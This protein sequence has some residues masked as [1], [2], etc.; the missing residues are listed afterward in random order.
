MNKNDI[1]VLLSARLLVLASPVAAQP[2]YKLGVGTHLQPSATVKVEG[3]KLSRSAIKDD[4]GFRLQYAI[5]KDGKPL[6]PIE[7]RA[8]VVVDVPKKE[9]GVYTAVLELFYPSYKAGNQQK[10]Q[11]KAISNVLSYKV[12]SG[13][14]IELLEPVPVLVIHCGKG[15]G[16]NESQKA[17]DGFSYKLLQG[18]PLDDWPNPAPKSHAWID[19]KMVRFEITLPATAVGL[20]R[21]HCLDGDLRERKQKISV[22][23]R[24]FEFEK[25][26]GSAQTLEVPLPPGRD[27]KTAGKIE[28]VI[29]NL[30]PTSTA[31]IS[32]VEL[33]A[34]PLTK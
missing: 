4:P 1:F 29:Q 2:T 11:F 31:A 16:T 34:F 6:E 23:D 17:V 33:L 20:L 21:L 13:G 15:K 5:Y 24:V 7:A 22:L 9:A 14:Q 27:P 8:G 25:F 12:G 28:V 32:S 18:T 30:N 10:G 19:P 26:G 3:D